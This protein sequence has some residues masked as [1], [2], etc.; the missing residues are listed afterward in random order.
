[1]LLF[2]SRHLILDPAPISNSASECWPRLAAS[3]ERA[4][5]AMFRHV[6]E[7]G[8]GAT[9][10]V[11]SRRLWPLPSVRRLDCVAVDALIPLAITRNA[12]SWLLL[13]APRGPDVSLRA[14]ELIS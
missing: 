1:M 14:F 3:E 10:T 4:R 13:T 9:V 11:I 12:T 6:L 5:P 8:G 2:A 7:P